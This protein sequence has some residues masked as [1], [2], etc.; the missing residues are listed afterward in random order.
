MYP[1]LQLLVVVVVAG[2]G[3]APTPADC[4]DA[5]FHMDPDNCPE[6]YFCC[7]PDGQGGWNIQSFTC[8]PGT[9]FNPELQAS[10][11]Q[12][13]GGPATNFVAAD[14]RLGWRLDRFCVRRSYPRTDPAHPANP[15]DLDSAS[16]QRGQAACLLLQQLGILPVSAIWSALMNS[17]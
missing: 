5:E 6:G 10:A 9:A 17:R 1:L 4:E 12:Y 14:V 15:A 8:D 7:T 3:A 13:K 16:A 11:T 2:A